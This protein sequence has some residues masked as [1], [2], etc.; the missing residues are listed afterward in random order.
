MVTATIPHHPVSTVV[1][2][3]HMRWQPIEDFPGYSIS[4][5]GEVRN[6]ETERILLRTKNQ[7]GILVVGLMKE[8][9]QY[10][11]S[12]ALL[13]AK[14]F[15]PPPTPE[16][17]D[18]VIHLDGDRTNVH[19][20]NLVWR[21]RWFAVRYHKQFEPGAPRGFEQS[22]QDTKTGIIYKTSWEAATQFGLIDRE[23]LIATLNRTYVWPTYQE[24]K[25]VMPTKDTSLL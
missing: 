10:K 8:G 15:L 2:L 6:D 18:T 3:V 22:I 5:E 20:S 19:E 23:I 16:S 1:A 12:V 13:V 11:R 25:V 14:A 4:E 24:F 7:R 21:P 9:K 17:F